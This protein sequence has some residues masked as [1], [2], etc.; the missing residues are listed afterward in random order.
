MGEGEE[1]LT[2]S[3]SGREEEKTTQIPGILHGKK[4]A[5]RVESTEHV[6]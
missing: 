4:W 1:G 5:I 3:E 6:I 2:N